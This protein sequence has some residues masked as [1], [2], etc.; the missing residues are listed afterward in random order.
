MKSVFVNGLICWIKTFSFKKKQ[1]V[2]YKILVTVLVRIL[3]RN[4]FTDSFLFILLF[5]FY[6][7][8]TP[9]E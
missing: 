5:Y 8:Y 9:K 6:H 7:F 1:L 4:R 3:L 2:M